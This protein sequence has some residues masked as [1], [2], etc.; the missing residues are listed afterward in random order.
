MHLPTH[1][2]TPLDPCRV[3][4]FLGLPPFTSDRLDRLPLAPPPPPPHHHV[5]QPPHPPVPIS[6]SSGP[7]QPPASHP[8]YPYLPLHPSSAAVAAAMATHHALQPMLLFQQH[9]AALSASLH[10]T[11]AQSHA[12]ISPAATCSPLILDRIPTGTLPMPPSALLSTS[13]PAPNSTPSSP[14]SN[15][16]S[17][18]HHQHHQ[19][20]HLQQS[21]VNNAPIQHLPKPVDS[22]IK[23]SNNGSSSNTKTNTISTKNT[24]LHTVER[25]MAPTPAPGNIKSTSCPGSPASSPPIPPGFSLHQQPNYPP[26]QQNS[27]V[28]HDHYHNHQQQ[29]HHRPGKNS[30]T[31]VLPSA[32]RP[33]N[34]SSPTSPSPRSSNTSPLSTS[35]ATTG[36]SGLSNNST[37]TNNNRGIVNTS[38]ASIAC[39]F[40]PNKTTSIADLRL[41]ARQHLASLGI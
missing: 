26:P 39:G 35:G 32:R 5:H 10:S 33:S 21:L 8:F 22:N 16:S 40:Q 37:T 34:P 31:P 23:T 18:A 28:I 30:M 13:V 38:P 4:P 29:H 17:G 7:S 2:G 12:H 15:G 6:S 20:L 19:H 27:I 1:L 11:H 24:N 36:N 9:L 41:K 14:A 3:S 25:I